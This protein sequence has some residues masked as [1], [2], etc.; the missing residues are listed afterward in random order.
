MKNNQKAG[1]KN[2]KKSNI[3]RPYK[4]VGARYRQLRSSLDTIQKDCT[5]VELSKEISISPAQISELENDKKFP[6]ITELTTY[7]DYFNVPV[8]YLLGR[9]DTIDYENQKISSSL[10]LSDKAIERLVYMSKNKESSTNH[11]S[12]INCIFESG[13][14]DEFWELLY[15]YL[16]CDLK[17]IYQDTEI[18][19]TDMVNTTFEC[20]KKKVN[21][22]IPIYEADNIHRMAFISTLDAI[23]KKIREKGYKAENLNDRPIFE[24]VKKE[25]NAEDILDRLYAKRDKKK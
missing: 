12:I 2:D 6:S 25:K 4:K 11:L 24:R 19:D 20:N 10:G 22:M 14:D 3:K 13:C 18:K 7:A 16:F 9:I 1:E 23:K 17:D 21:F 5:I 15:Y 8:D